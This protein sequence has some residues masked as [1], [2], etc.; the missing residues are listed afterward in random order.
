M[1]KVFLTLG[2]AAAS[3]WASA[4]QDT[5]TLD[6]TVIT[7]TRASGKTP[8]AQTVVSEK[9]IRRANIGVDIPYIME[10]TPSV[11]VSSESGLGL[12]NT[13]FRIRGTDPSRINVTVNGIPVNDAESQAVFWVN[14]PDFASSV[15]SIQIQRGVG[16]STNGGAAFGATVNM[17][18]SRSSAV[19]YAEISSTAGMYGTF[20]NS[21]S[22]GT[23]TVGKGFAFD[24]RYS[25]VRSDG[26]IERSAA[27]H[28]SLYASGAW[29]GDCTS[30]KFSILHG[31]EHTGLSWNGVPGYAL[32]SVKY[33]Y[34]EAGVP[35]YKPGINRRYNPSGEYRDPDGQIRYY[36][37]T[38]NYRQ[39]HYH[40]QFAQQLAEHWRGHATLHLTRGIGYY[41]EYR[42]NRKLEEHG[43]P[44]VEIDGITAGR[45]DLIRQKWMDNYF[46]GLTF[47]ANYSGGRL[48]W[49]T[50]GAANRHDGDH[51]GKV[52]W[53]RYNAGATSGNEWYRNNGTKNDYNFYTKA[54]WQ[55]N[56]LINIYGDLQYRHIGY[57][58]EGFDDDLA[59]LG[60][61]HCFNFFN[62]KAGAFF[63]INDRNTA[64]V[65]FAVANREPTR[66]DFKDASKWGASEA[67]RSERLYDTELGYRITLPAVSME[68]NL[69][70][71]C[72]K[73]QLVST[74]KLSSVGYPIM[75]N[76]PESYRAGIE[77]TGGIRIAEPLRF[78]ATATFS[79]NKIKNFIAFT[80]RYDNNRDW[81]SMEQRVENL[82]N[83]DISFSPEL[84]GSAVL[85]YTPVKNLSFSIGGKYVGKQYY[86][87]TSD[88]SRSLDAYFTGNFGVDYSFKLYG[89]DF[90]LQGLINNVFDRRYI[91][92]A[93]V[94]RAVFEDGSPDYIE[95]GFFPQA[96]RN[97]I[98]KLTIAF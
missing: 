10:M 40:L 96:G 50:G 22:L 7:A 91:T 69:Y 70:Y 26:Y 83:T 62:P 14:M 52:L 98:G 93:W 15:G 13:T 77:L 41:E 43:L 57:V 88:D 36:N 94:Y 3:M 1:K 59:E 5:I 45:S 79:R 85:R 2:L 48:Q 33:P 74:G 47:S 8:V 87:N 12:G 51:F 84:T 46:Y 64:Y 44:N 25:N 18:T 75:E 60:Q 11:I 81:G 29:Q 54:T 53:A 9:E 31:E 72:Y 49:T 6:E 19:P 58:M 92:S 68:V 78:E 76:I 23:G 65:S 89:I 67:P 27:K 30:V 21:I 95:N 55:P 39:T 66:A 28:Q 86:D 82:G 24:A 20:R 38:D 61:S 35:D 34:F 71:M 73:D 97:V 17:Q 63:N 42:L 56:R 37:N 32:D 80:D 90:G 16:T 4:Q